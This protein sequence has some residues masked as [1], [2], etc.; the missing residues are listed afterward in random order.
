MNI[1]DYPSLRLLIPFLGGVIIFNA[2]G[3]TRISFLLLILL[4]ALLLFVTML[5]LFCGK[6]LAHLYGVSLCLSFSLLGFLL[7]AYSSSKVKADWPSGRIQYSGMLKNYPLEKANSYRLDLELIDSVYG[8]YNIIL[9][10]PKDSLVQTIEP[11]NLISFRG[12]VKSPS[13]ESIDGDFDYARYLYRN[14][15]SGTLWVDS[16][17][18]KLLADTLLDVPPAVVALKCRKYILDKYKEW[19]LKDDVLAVV[20][21]VTVGYKDELTDELRAVYSTSGASHVLAVSGLHV[22]ILFSILSFFFPLFTNNRKIVWIKEITVV[23]VMWGYA[24]II[25]LPYSIT[26]SLIMFSL[27]AV[28]KSIGRENS[29][30]NA[31]A[32]AALVI[33]IANPDAIYDIGFQLSFSA[34]FSILLLEPYIRGIFAPRNIVLKYLWGIISVSLAAQAG[35][36]PLVMYNFSNFSTYFLLTNILVIPIMFVVVF[37]AVLMLLFC[38]VPVIRNLMVLLL[39]KLVTI[40]NKLLLY[41]TELPSSS[42]VIQNISPYM[43]CCIYISMFLLYCYLTRKKTTYLVYLLL[44]VTIWSVVELFVFLNYNS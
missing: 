36:A 37:V 9:Y 24:F 27:L 11:G 19:G 2:I 14:G 40:V 4:F 31:L 8:G 25:G 22:G 13:N 1:T 6:K 35:T 10:V 23:C 41:I 39:E 28:C 12:V 7:S 30:L 42:I 33:L 18:W 32:F 16:R 5:F 17:N 3:D 26:R 15:I 21:A 34:V 20:A 43:V 38:C 44:V 29:S